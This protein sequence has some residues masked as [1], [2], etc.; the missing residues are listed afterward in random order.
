MVLDM[1][2]EPEDGECQACRARAQKP[3]VR[4]W[5]GLARVDFNK[6]PAPLLRW[7]GI[8]L[9]GI[10]YAAIGAPTRLGDW[11]WAAII[12]GG[13]LLPDV[14]RFEFAGVKIELRKT[15]KE[16]EDQIASIRN[17]VR[18]NASASNYNFNLPPGTTPEQL[19]SAIQAASRVN[20]AEHDQV[21]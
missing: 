12:G 2:G 6:P 8:A 19:A 16:L 7:T 1:T 20:R 15:R 3:H 21:E 4:I 13:L 11:L 5:R 14:T 10:I 9:T 17:E 18:A